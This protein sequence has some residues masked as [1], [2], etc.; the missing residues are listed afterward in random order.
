MDIKELKT[1]QNLTELFRCI[2]LIIYMIAINY[3]TNP[4][5]LIG[6]SLIGATAVHLATKTMRLAY[7]ERE[8]ENEKEEEKSVRYTALASLLL[9]VSITSLTF[10]GDKFLFLP[11]ISLITFYLCN[12]KAAEFFRK[13]NKEEE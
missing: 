12:R 8:I 10:L 2:L 5:F 1:T 3:V 7:K 9:I 11:I 13:D 6:T 4:I